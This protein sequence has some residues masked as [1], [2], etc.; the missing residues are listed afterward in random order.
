MSARDPFTELLDKIEIEATAYM[1]AGP[2]QGGGYAW[3]C[4]LCHTGQ[5]AM[6]RIPAIDQHS[7]GIGGLHHL[8]GPDH[9]AQEL[10]AQQA[11][12]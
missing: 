8:L 3:W 10:L 4:H 6:T 2:I 9:E 12:S 1:Q 5:S 11:G 7:V